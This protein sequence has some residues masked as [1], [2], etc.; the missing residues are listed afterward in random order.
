MSQK[1]LICHVYFI[2]SI[3]DIVNT[4]YFEVS[5]YIPILSI[6]SFTFSYT[7]LNSTMKNPSCF[8]LSLTQLQ[9]SQK[10]WIYTEALAQK[11]SVKKLFLEISQN[12]QEKTCARIFSFNKVI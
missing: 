3:P 1:I 12:S 9:K 8:Q 6:L 2:N 7:F 10:L 5:N 11:C 4:K